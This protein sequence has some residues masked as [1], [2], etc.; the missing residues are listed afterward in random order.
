[1]NK[2]A[3]CLDRWLSAVH[4]SS[5]LVL[6]R[7]FGGV[8]MARLWRNSSDNIRQRAWLG[9]CTVMASP[10]DIRFA[11]GARAAL[12]VG[13]TPRLWRTYVGCAGF[14]GELQAREELDPGTLESDFLEAVQRGVISASDLA[15]IGASQCKRR[16]LL[17]TAGYVER[18][19][20]EI[21]RQARALEDA[22][23]E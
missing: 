17:T 18:W 14:I 4:E 6:L 9:E 3:E 22:C 11:R 8:G 21:E 1:M 2:S 7:K 20:P 13:R 19:W 10:G 16:H 23:S 5:H 12:G 15:L